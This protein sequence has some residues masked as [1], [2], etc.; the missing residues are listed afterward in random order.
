MKQV[1]S[2]AVLNAD[3]RN[4]AEMNTSFNIIRALTIV[5]IGR[6]KNHSH[7]FKYLEHKPFK[8]L[9]LYTTHVLNPKVAFKFNVVI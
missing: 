5:L 7:I 1:N 8:Q 6:D 3:M 4:E 9:Q 2:Y